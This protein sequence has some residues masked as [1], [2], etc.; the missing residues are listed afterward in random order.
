MGFDYCEVTS[1]SKTFSAGAGAVAVFALAAAGFSAPALAGGMFDFMD[2]GE[3]FGGND[4]DD[5]WYD[6]YRW[7][8]PWGYGYGGP[9]GGPYGGP[10]G[11]GAPW[12]AYP[13]G[14]P[15]YPPAGGSSDNK[16]PERVPQ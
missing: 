12:G 7:G 14:Y 3:W 9:W 16:Q 11:Y 15:Y 13:Y 8:G 2:P 10:W 6:R 1:M 5:W 4:Y